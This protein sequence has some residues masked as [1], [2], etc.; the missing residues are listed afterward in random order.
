M[1]THGRYYPEDIYHCVNEIDHG[2]SRA[3]PEREVS[4]ATTDRPIKRNT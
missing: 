3:S 1:T 4:E 2:A